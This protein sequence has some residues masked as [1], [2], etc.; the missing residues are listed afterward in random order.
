MC[1]NGFKGVKGDLNLLFSIVHQGIDYVDSLKAKKVG[2]ARV[3]EV[4][5]QSEKQHLPHAMSKPVSI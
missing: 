5:L 1:G 3:N 2:Y 4:G